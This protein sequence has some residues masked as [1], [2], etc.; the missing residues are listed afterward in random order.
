MELQVEGAGCDTWSWEVTTWDPLV[1]WPWGWLRLIPIKLQC[2]QLRWALVSVLPRFFWLPAPVVASHPLF[3][4]SPQSLAPMNHI[5]QKG[6][7][8]QS[9]PLH[10]LGCGNCLLSLL[11]NLVLPHKGNRIKWNA[12]FPISISLA[13]SSNCWNSAVLSQLD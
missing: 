4:F 7:R 11:S 5:I 2:H 6:L 12:S 3:V 8:S 10:T 13:I 9:L 1:S